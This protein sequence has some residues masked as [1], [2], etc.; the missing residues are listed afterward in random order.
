MILLKLHDQQ[1]KNKQ[2][3]HILL[4]LNEYMLGFQVS[5]PTMD[6]VE[7]LMQLILISLDLS[8][9]VFVPCIVICSE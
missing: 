6:Q 3:N 4:N 2:K 7:N 1:K 5:F 9:L 8:V